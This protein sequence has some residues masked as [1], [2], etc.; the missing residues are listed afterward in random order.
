MYGHTFLRFDKNLKT[1][2]ISNALNYSA[3]TGETSGVVFA[4]KGLLGG[5]RGYFSTMSYYEKIKE[6]NDLEQRDIWEYN[7]NL[8]PTEI[9]RMLLHIFEIEKYYSDYF[10]IDENCSYNLLWLL[11]IARPNLDLVDRFKYVVLPIDTIREVIN[12]D[13][14]DSTFYRESLMQ[15]MQYILHKK[16]EDKELAKRFLNDPSISLDHLDRYQQIYILD[17]ASLYIPYKTRKDNLV[18]K[19]NKK[20][21]LRDQLKLLRKRSKLGKIKEYE[22]PKPE[23]PLN[24]HLSSKA[25]VFINSDDSIDL[26]I[27]LGYHDMLDLETSFVEGAYIDFLHLT[28]N[29]TKDETRLKSLKLLNMKSFVKRD[30]LFKPIS[31]GVEFGVEDFYNKNRVKL[32]GDVGLTYG[33]KGYYY[34]FDLNPTIYHKDNTL[35]GLGATI[36]YIHNFKDMKV[37]ANYNKTKYDEKIKQNHFE[38]FST[39]AVLKNSAIG[40]KYTYDKL[41]DKKQVD[42]DEF[43][44]VYYFY[45]F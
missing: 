15:K 10:F 30:I 33:D 7:L 6:Y 8:N 20:Q 11:E 35:A 29:Q 31:W 28:I 26:G 4:Y 25:E 37:G 34:F 9:N 17:L 24:T 12:Q 42:R 5:Y 43:V 13:L 45:Y 36:G 38:I 27:K 22:F 1:P 2:L 3:R 14:V 18:T 41:E 44:S 19:E 16:I 32:K 23:S 40:L 39:K 21:Y